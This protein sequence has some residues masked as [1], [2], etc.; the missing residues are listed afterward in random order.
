VKWSTLLRGVQRIWPSRV[1][2]RYDV[3]RISSPCDFGRVG[4]SVG[5]DLPLISERI[6]SK[7]PCR[8]QKL[9]TQQAYKGNWREAPTWWGIRI[10]T[11][12]F[13]RSSFENPRY[14]D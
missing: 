11:A 3:D 13:L 6:S 4:S 8:A 10:Y 9:V 7:K 5:T 2:R 1:L 12:R 14:L